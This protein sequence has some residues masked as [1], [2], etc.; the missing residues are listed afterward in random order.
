M[1]NFLVVKS[2]SWHWYKVEAVYTSLRTKI[3]S[4]GRKTEIGTSNPSLARN[5]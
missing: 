2:S 3:Y 5:V 1:K 4:V